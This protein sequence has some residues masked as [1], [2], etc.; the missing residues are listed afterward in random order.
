MNIYIINN[1]CKGMLEPQKTSVNISHPAGDFSSLVWWEHKFQPEMIGMRQNIFVI[2][3]VQFRC[4]TTFSL[5]L[6]HNYK[7]VWSSLSQQ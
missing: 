4:F 5:N 6:H 7:E 3:L 1:D 2:T